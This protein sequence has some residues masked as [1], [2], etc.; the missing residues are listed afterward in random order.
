MWYCEII[1]RL[2]HDVGA[3]KVSPNRKLGYYDAP[4]GSGP[5]RSY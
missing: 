2:E 1:G 3:P 4:E 5:I